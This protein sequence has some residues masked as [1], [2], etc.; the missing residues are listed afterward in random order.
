MVL[1]PNTPAITQQSVSKG[2]VLAVIKGADVASTPVQKV[3]D[4]KWQQGK[5][6][7]LSARSEGVCSGTAKITNNQS[8][9]QIGQVLS[10]VIAAPELRG[11]VLGRLG[12]W[13]EIA[14]PHLVV[15]PDNTLW[16]IEKVKLCNRPGEWAAFVASA[17]TKG[18]VRSLP[19]T[20]QTTVQLPRMVYL[21]P[22]LARYAVAS[23]RTAFEMHKFLSDM[24]ASNDGGVS[25]ADGKFLLN[26]FMATGQFEHGM[27]TQQLSSYVGQ[28][29]ARAV[30]Q[31]QPQQQTHQANAYIQSMTQ[32]LTEFATTHRAV[33]S[34][35][36]KK[37][38]EDKTLNEYDIAALCGFCGV[39]ERHPRVWMMQGPIL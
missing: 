23:E 18:E 15:M 14:M 29:P 35:Q 27:S 28:G 5:D 2:A 10:P 6:K 38:E 19:A 16:A 36:A 4:F 25:E 39:R 37:S 31:Q 26:W 33:L 24:I 34:D 30:V 17:A 32:V 1:F 8:G 22:C 9:A 21:P 13:T 20:P 3:W 11:R 12:D 7:G